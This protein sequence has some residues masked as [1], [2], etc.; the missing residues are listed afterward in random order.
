[1][2]R[3]SL[4]Q[5]VRA[6]RPQPWSILLGIGLVLTLVY[7]QLPTRE[8]QDLFYQLPETVAFVAV[9]LG[10]R[11]LRPA[12][13]GP[14]YLLALGIGLTSAGDWTWVVL[15]RVYGIDP[16][17]SVAD[18][19][20]LG[21]MITI[22]FAVRG[23]LHG[24]IPGGDRAGVLDALIVTVGVGLL[25]W[26]F[27]MAPIAADTTQSPGELAV[28]LA[29]PAIDLLL[30]GVLVR[31]VLAPGEM[32]TAVR[33][34]IAGLL[35]FLLAD[36]QYALLTLTDGYAVGSPID[37][38]WLLGTTFW[39]AA[40]LH[41]S[42]RS[43]GRPGQPASQLRA[44]RL[45]LLALASLL[46]PAVLVAESLAGMPVDAP[47]VAVGCIVI[48][49]LVIARLEGVVTDLR[50]T[51]DERTLLERELERRALHDPLTG[52]A[53]RVLFHDRLSHALARR[54]GSVAVMFLDL[55]DFK[56]INDSF[57]HDAGDRVLQAVATELAAVA[58]AGDTVARLGGDEFA[59]LI[60][61]SPDRFAASR[62][63]GRLLDAVRAPI[64]VA[65]HARSVG[66]S[67]GISLGE[68]GT[69]DADV[70]MRE[71]DI[72][73]YV[74]KG[75][76]K[77]TY[78]VFEPSELHSVVRGLELRNDLEQAVRE[79]QFELDYQPIF[80]LDSG[81]MA[82]VEAL[83]R[84]RHPVQGRLLPSEFIGLTETTGAIVPLGRWMLQQAGRAAAG[85][86][87]PFVSVNLSAQQLEV[88][89]FVD[90]V[91]EVLRTSG[92]PP[93]RLVLELTETS[94]LDD[95]VAAHAIWPL[96]EMGVRLALDDF[97]TGFAA[98]SQLSRSWF[99]IVKIDRSFLA[100]LSSDPRA[101]S[102]VGGILDLARRLGVVAVAEGIEDGVQLA[103]LRDAGCPLG[104]G[105]L[106][107]RPIPPAEL[108]ALL[109]DGAPSAAARS[110]APSQ[111]APF[112][113]RSA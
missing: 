88:A 10:I 58:R 55:D 80:D 28:A 63:A 18:L 53:N 3:A 43:L 45:A 66:A 40:A 62:L 31:L 1:M 104:Q 100:D 59:L 14:W 5:R 6:L 94:R 9:L 44:W 90:D 37:A 23:M 95:E 86:N 93:D 87:G 65:G 50:R 7:F 74:A 64:E 39:G 35:A 46:G 8:G 99:D 22:A 98:L 36:F 109:R 106:F 84:W 85:W 13:A 51:L 67:I 77:G 30:L 42:M 16:F 12:D 26:V 102:L 61:D 81:E 76:G 25:S 47:V 101:E 48:F 19:F 11:L 73:M 97:G 4:Q 27:L 21:G 111:A 20:Y 17:P 79:H 105:F 83:V 49:G 41:P 92:L 29:Y 32:V 78:T 110:A 15:D 54:A 96:R 56:T 82:G 69:A 52:L 113:P 68:C 112:R 57:G 103:R 60:E 24:R 71:A 107:A 70:L 34:L 89:S 38:G 33:L 2:L 75:G 108:V 91:R 72:A